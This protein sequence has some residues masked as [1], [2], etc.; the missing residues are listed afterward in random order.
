MWE[1]VERSVPLKNISDFVVPGK[2]RAPE[3]DGS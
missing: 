3:G 1:M 2:V